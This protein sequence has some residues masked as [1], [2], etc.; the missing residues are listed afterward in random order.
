MKKI[1]LVGQ[2]PP[3]FHGQAVVTQMLFEHHWGEE[4][5]VSSLRM[6]YSKNIDEVGSA[7]FTKVL[8][9]VSL[10][11]KTWWIVISKHPQVLYYP[12]AGGKTVPI[13]RDIIYLGLT[14]FLFK[15]TVFH[16][17]AGG[18]TD[19][20][21]Q[22]SFIAG[23]ARK[24]YQSPDVSI[25]LY[26]EADSPGNY[27]NAKNIK[28]IANGLE[29]SKPQ[30]ETEEQADQLNLLFVGSLSESKGILQLIKTAQLLEQQSVAFNIQIAGSWVNLAFKE[31]SLQLIKEYKLENR[32]EFIGLIQGDAKWEAYH[33]ADIFFFPS[34]YEA[35]KFP[36][37]LIEAMGCHCSII[38]TTWRGIPQLVEGS[39]AAIL[40]DI[41]SP[42]QY[43]QAIMNLGENR[44]KLEQMKQSAR[45]HY[46]SYYSKDKFLAEVTQLFNNI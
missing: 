8:H 38:T 39:A 5:E 12:P 37:V 19:Y 10:I 14:R 6:S 25:E 9:L 4:L 27:L 18:L 34:H 33:R 11:I 45:A 36:L 43:A 42:D 26:K 46:L 13:L 31:E 20:L 21:K 7:G 1:L 41:K 17:H 35:E 28:I 22:P 30:G 32:I 24:I 2:T 29:V 3:P 44:T 15:K 40:D 16:F 23:L